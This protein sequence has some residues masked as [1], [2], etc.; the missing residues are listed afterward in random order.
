[1]EIKRKSLYVMLSYTN[2]I[3]IDFFLEAVINGKLIQSPN[4]QVKAIKVG[5][6]GEDCYK[7]GNLHYMYFVNG[8]IT[9]DDSRIITY[10]EMYNE[11]IEIDEFDPVVVTSIKR[12]FSMH[13]ELKYPMGDIKKKI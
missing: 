7:C 12:Y 11:N 13:K 8:L 3:S 4:I 5:F 1:M 2:S 9:K 6:I 10:E